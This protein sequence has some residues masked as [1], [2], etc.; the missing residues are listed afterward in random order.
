MK[1]AMLAFGTRGDVQPFV[2]LGL[3]L[4]SAGYQVILATQY[5]FYDQ[6]TSAGLSCAPIN[7]DVRLPSQKSVTTGRLSPI[8]VYRL[9]RHYMQQA[10][11]EMWDVCRD[12]DALIF[13]DWG[14]LP[15]V[16]IIEKLH[17]PALMI[18][19]HPQQ[20]QFLYRETHVFGSPLAPWVSQ[21]RKQILWQFVVRGLMNM[22]RRQT[23]QLP[24]APFWGNEQLLKEWK[25]P[26]FFAHSPTVFPKPATWPDW[27]HVTGYLFLD[28]AGNWTPSPALV[29]FLSAGPPPVLIGFSSMSNRKVK[30]LADVLLNAL[31]MAKQRGI[32]LTGWS[33]IG[34][35]FSMPKDVFATDMAPH[36]WLFPQVAAVVHHGGAGTTAAGFCAGI[37][38]VII[39]FALD[40]PFWAWRVAELGSGPPALAPGV[41]TAERLAQ[42]ITHGVEN[43]AIRACAT[44]LGTRIRAEDGVGNAVTLFEQYVCKS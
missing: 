24:A 34:T 17:I 11:N 5:R 8:A 36:D 6:V 37:P 1:I 12:A 29:E 44:D 23:L 38:Q 19:T 3:G 41:L 7:A 2:A 27:F 10:L 31:S 20:M 25:T 42:V 39:P 26:V 33:K 13:S 32:I 28:Q 9:T 30:N 40:Q 4:Q 43:P 22:W 14:R 15:A 16:P 18:L 35:S 21:L